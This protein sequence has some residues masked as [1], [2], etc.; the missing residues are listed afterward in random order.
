M[1]IAPPIELKDQE[2]QKLLKLR[3]SR[4]TAVRLIERLD[5][6]L[7]AY[8]GKTNQAIAEQLGVSENKVTRWRTRY[9]TG[10]LKA[11]EK[12]RPRGRNHAGKSSLG[13]A[14][15]R[16]KIIRATT[17]EA[18]AEGT[19]WTSRTLAKNSIRHIVSFIVYGNR[20]A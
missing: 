9:H 17:Q 2:Y 4:T 15:L 3:N 6:V 5:I 18:P 19:H 13:Q 1:R 14:R 16:N 11:L 12:D 8:E 7:L 20:W 10:G